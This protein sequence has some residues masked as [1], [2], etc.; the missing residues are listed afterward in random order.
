MTTV[1]GANGAPTKVP[2]ININLLPPLEG[3]PPAGKLIIAPT[4]ATKGMPFAAELQ[5]PEMKAA[6][7]DGELQAPEGV[8]I[9]NFEKSTFVTKEFTVKN[10][11]NAQGGIK[12]SIHFL[13]AKGT[14][15]VFSQTNTKQHMVFKVANV[16]FSALERNVEALQSMLKNHIEALEKG[17]IKPGTIEEMLKQIEADRTKE[18]NIKKAHAP[19]NNRKP[20][21][22]TSAVEAFHGITLMPSFMQS[23][24]QRTTTV[25]ASA[26]GVFSVA[27]KTTRFEAAFNA[28]SIIGNGT[29]PVADLFTPETSPKSS[30]PKPAAPKPQKTT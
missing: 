3:Q 26:D 19:S 29:V 13:D 7:R 15:R 27:Q 5:F 22:A 17:E 9:V 23:L 25:S 10:E 30:P 20:E 21:H 14:V 8:L 12:D 2:V 6:C 1:F 24:S 11:K 18:K 4:E 28:T 16:P